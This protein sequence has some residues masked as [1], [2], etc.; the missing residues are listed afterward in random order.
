[1]Q[2]PVGNCSAIGILT[3]VFSFQLRGPPSNRRALM[4]VS[5]NDLTTGASCNVGVNHSPVAAILAASGAI[6]GMAGADLIS[7]E[8]FPDA[9]IVEERRIGV[10]NV[11][12][13]LVVFDASYATI[14]GQFQFRQLIVF[15]AR[16]SEVFTITCGALVNGF[17]S[18]RPVFLRLVSSFVFESWEQ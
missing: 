7:K 11:P 1:M 5:S 6:P 17:E 13:K 4:Y 3:F 14:Q 15:T 16:D 8:K 10:D 12:A 9:R 2:T 18:M